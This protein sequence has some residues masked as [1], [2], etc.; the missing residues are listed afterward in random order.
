MRNLA[1]LTTTAALALFGVAN[2]EEAPVSGDP[3]QAAIGAYAAYQLDITTLRTTRL[4]DAAALEQVIDRAASHNRNAVGR[5][6]IGYGASTASQSRQFVDGVRDA[7]RHYGR[8]AMISAL[9]GN[10]AYARTLPGGNDATKLVLDA[11]AADGA[12]IVEVA[13]RYREQAYTLQRQRWANAVAPAQAARVQRVRNLAAAGSTAASVSD[14]S[15]RLAVTPISLQPGS[16]PSA[17]GGRRFWETVRGGAQV[18]PVANTVTYQFRVDPGRGEAVNRMLTISALQALDA[19]TER[20]TTVS[21]LL[22]EPRTEY[23]MQMAQLQLYQCMS[24]ARFR[25]ENAFCLAQ[26]AMRDVGTCI[27]AV[28]TPD[29]TAMTPAPGRGG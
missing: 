12:R 28:A 23:C 15:P 7:A 27:S 13:E 24:A 21:A 1:V 11:S 29:S 26:H 20:A 25:Y 17:F 10:P 6:W 4:G 14:V 3:S 22:S 2:A 9:A 5:G 16:D 8:D 19:G 18:T